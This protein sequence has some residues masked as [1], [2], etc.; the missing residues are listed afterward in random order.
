MLH[1]FLRIVV[2]VRLRNFSVICPV[3]FCT[4]VTESHIETVSLFMA[5]CSSPSL[6]V[7][8]DFSPPAECGDEANL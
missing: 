6:V 3:C 1:R 7:F 4:C 5:A 8:L 2:S